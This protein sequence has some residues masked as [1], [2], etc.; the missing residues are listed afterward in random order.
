MR[1]DPTTA[2]ARESWSGCRPAAGTGAD[3]AVIGVV[4]SRDRRPAVDVARALR[5]ADSALVVAF[6]GR[7]APEE[8][9]VLRLPERLTD[10][11]GRLSG[12]LNER[13]AARED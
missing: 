12:T 6:G 11:V 10:A 3:A 4:T 13:R 7:A 9:G 1:P 2:P 8:P 5:V